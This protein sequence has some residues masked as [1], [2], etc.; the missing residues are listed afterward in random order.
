MTQVWSKSAE[1]MKVK[2]SSYSSNN[3]SWEL[4]ISGNMKQS[5]R[6]LGLI[7]APFLPSFH[8]TQTCTNACASVHD[9]TLEYQ[10]LLCQA[11][12]DGWGGSGFWFSPHNGWMIFSVEPVLPLLTQHRENL[13]PVTHSQTPSMPSSRPALSACQRIAPLFPVWL[14]W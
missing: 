4:W 2:D 8:T 9:H 5:L 13:Y 1:A 12:R 3:D 11:E 14:G 10:H 7:L 6:L